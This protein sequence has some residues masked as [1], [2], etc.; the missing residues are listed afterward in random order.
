MYSGQ[1]VS[2]AVHFPCLCA[3]PIGV[4]ASI[5]LEEFAPKNW[6]T[7]L[8]EVN[9]AN[10]AAVPKPAVSFGLAAK[11]KKAPGPLAIF[12]FADEDE[13]E[14]EAGGEPGGLGF[15]L[16]LGAG[17]GGLCALDAGEKKENCNVIVICIV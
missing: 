17:C 9:I 2:E 14:D 4:A 16:G 11:P 1:P 15:G 3:L 12:G 8:I 10:L 5:Y 7:D 6:L 13:D